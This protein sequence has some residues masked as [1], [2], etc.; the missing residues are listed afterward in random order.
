[1]PPKCPASA[2]RAAIVA[3]ARAEFLAHGYGAT[4]MSAIAARVGGSKT[5]LWTYFPSKQELFAAVVDDS[6]E[7]FGAALDVPL[8]PELPV[9]TRCAASAKA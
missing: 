9:K 4:A 6:V 8:E 3:A 2:K 5:T 1:M 7:R